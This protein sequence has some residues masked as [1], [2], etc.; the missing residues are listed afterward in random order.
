MPI[1]VLLSDPIYLFSLLTTYIT[2]RRYWGLRRTITLQRYKRFALLFSWNT[3][4]VLW[5]NHSAAF[6]R[7]LLHLSLLE[8]E[9]SFAFASHYTVPTTNFFPPVLSTPPYCPFHF[10]QRGDFFG[11]FFPPLIQVITHRVPIDIRVKKLEQSRYDLSLFDVFLL[12]E[13]STKSTESSSNILH[14]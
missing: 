8:I 1:L 3:M 7:C 13:S 6:I 9:K 11:F 4:F 10:W 12:R 5:S 14:H 2:N